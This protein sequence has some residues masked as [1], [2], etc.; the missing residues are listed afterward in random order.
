MNQKKAKALRRA[1]GYR[2]ATATPSAI[3]FPGVARMVKFPTVATRV[4][5][6]IVKGYPFWPRKMV[7]LKVQALSSVFIRAGKWWQAEALQMIKTKED[8]TV[9]P[10]FELVAFS[11]PARHNTETPR[12]IYRSLKKLERTV[13]LEAVAAGVQEAGYGTP[14]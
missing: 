7:E 8:G 12:G 9:E 10:Q 14:V 3:K 6:K 1:A 13:G 11:K 2:N 4:V 5:T